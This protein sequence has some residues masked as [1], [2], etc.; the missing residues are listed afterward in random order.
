MATAAVATPAPVP[1]TAGLSGAVGSSGAD[2]NFTGREKQKDVRHFNITAAKAVADCIRT[3]LGPKGM[4]KM[5]TSS[6][7]D[8]VITNDGATIL[9]KME[10]LHPAA[11]MLV[12]LSKAQDV[13]AGDGTTSVVVIAG[14]FLTA[15]QE[16]LEKGIHPSIISEAWLLAQRQAEVILKALAIPADLSAREGLVQSAVTSLNSKVVSANSQLLAPLAVDAVLR[17]IDP[18][19]AVNVSP[20]STQAAHNV[21]A[22][23]EPLRRAM[24]QSHRVEV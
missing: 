24:Q 2:I 22:Q 19:T 8:V 5:I 11:R 10:V 12:D 17:I 21:D 7:G 4:D 14:A 9:N 20:L 13:E 1:S 3:S 18:A 23:H 15:A 6:G 16:L